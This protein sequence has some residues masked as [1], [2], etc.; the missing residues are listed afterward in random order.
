VWTGP[1]ATGEQHLT[2]A[3]LHELVVGRTERI[4]IVS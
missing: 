4:V 3:V 1:G 2:A